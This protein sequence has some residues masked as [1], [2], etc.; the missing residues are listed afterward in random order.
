MPPGRARRRTRADDA[1][2]TTGATVDTAATTT[3]APATTVPA[4]ELAGRTFV[5]TAATGFELAPGVQITLTFDGDRLSAT[6]GCNQ[7]DSTWSVD[8]DVLV[9][10]EIASTRMACEPATLMDQDTWLSSLLTSD[11]TVTLDGDTLTL[12]EGQSSITLAAA[13]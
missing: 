6:G 12:T 10:A 7:L 9:V 3:T 2:T 8:G 5:S 1:S 4:I 13:P 11:P